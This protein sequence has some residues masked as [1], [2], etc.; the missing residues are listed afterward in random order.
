MKSTL[1]RDAL[2]TMLQTIMAG[3]AVRSEGITV[4]DGGLEFDVLIHKLQIFLRD[5][6]GVD[7]DAYGRP[8]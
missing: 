6:F 4:N 1:E 7:V 8:L 3:Y 2:V 5:E